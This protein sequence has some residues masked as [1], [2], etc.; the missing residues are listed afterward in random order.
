[1]LGV[2]TGRYSSLRAVSAVNGA[3]TLV[4]PV[5]AHEPSS[6]VSFPSSPGCGIGLKRQTR[7]PV[8]TSNACTSPGG[9]FR[10][11][12]RSPTPL[13]TITRSPTT[14]GGEVFV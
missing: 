7:L 11:V 12:S 1:L 10:Y 9:S 3:Q 14:T 6:Q 5:Y 8:R 2:L 4:W 13:P